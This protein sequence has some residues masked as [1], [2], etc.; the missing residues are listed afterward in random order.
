MA[1]RPDG[2]IISGVKS[3]HGEQV[4][5]LGTLGGCAG[6]VVPGNEWIYE[7]HGLMSFR[8]KTRDRIGGR[9]HAVAPDGGIY[10]GSTIGAGNE[11]GRFRGH[12]V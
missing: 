9:V 4:T 1:P 6:Y 12:G 11:K 8:Q 7:G 3:V 5:A 2:A 10:F